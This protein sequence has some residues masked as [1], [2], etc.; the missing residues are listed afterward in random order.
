VDRG[1]LAAV[2]KALGR[3]PARATP[4]SG[5]C[6]GEVYRVDMADGDAV[7]V[8]R[9]EGP[10]PPAGQGLALEGWMLGYLAAHSR[11]PVP[12]VLHADDALLIME[13]LPG[14]DPIDAAAEA[15][16]AELLADLHGVTAPAFG[17]PRDTLIG[18][19]AQPNP[20]TAT[21]RA[22]FRDHR[23]LYMAREAHAAGRLPARLLARLDSFA[24]AL[25][26]FLDEPSAPALVHGDMWGGNVL[27]RGG[28]ITGFVDPA[29][30]YAD[31]EIELAFSTLFGTFGRAF[32]DRYAEIRPLRPGFFELRRDILNLYPLLVHVRLFGGGYVAS[33]ERVLAR[34]GF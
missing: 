19:L 20:E 28:R 29:L 34:H 27:A 23:L 4:L 7:V 15:H 18:G 32:F 8:K 12:A 26:R 24:A 10:G 14:G 2:E 11:L 1:W 13:Y 22:F 3:A 21:W 25:D 9:A 33:V 16:A 5:G 17:A 31:P 6:I 30:Y